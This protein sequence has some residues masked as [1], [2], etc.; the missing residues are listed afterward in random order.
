MILA[1]SPVPDDLAE[2][3]RWGVWLME[4]EDKVPYRSS[5][6][7]RAS[8]T[9]PRHWGPL[10][11]ARR[12]IAIRKYTGLAFAFFREDGLVG[13][14]L[15]NCLDRDHVKRWASGILERFGDTYMEVSPSGSGVKIWVRGS[16]PRNLCKVHV[17]DGGGI[18]MYDHARY[19]TFT[20]LVFR[21]APMQVENH[22]ADVLLLYEHLTRR[23][24][25]C[26]PL[27]PLQGGRIP[28]GQQ[29]STLV[30]IAG[31]LRA[32]RVCDKAIL[33]CLLAVNEHQCERPGPPVNIARIVRSTR[34]WG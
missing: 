17:T 16:L 14:D 13:I 7:G 5:S 19:F 3:D 32:R 31:T 29:H 21:D 23:N 1:S 34:R 18:E 15:D 6:G 11:L 4:N 26:W 33:A 2:L 10:E 9:D 20:G 24:R 12:A 30:S 22:T 25:R 8:S 27:Q 28:Y